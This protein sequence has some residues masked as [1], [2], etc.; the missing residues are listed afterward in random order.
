VWHC[1]KDL[2]QHLDFGLLPPRTVR[3]SASV[4]ETTSVWCSEMS[5]VYS[6]SCDLFRVPYWRAIQTSC[7]IL[8]IKSGL[9][10]GWRDGSAANSTDCSAK[11]PVFNSQQPHGGSHPSVMRS[12]TVLWY[13]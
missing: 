13:V 5:P 2:C 9:H 11:G 7:T 6:C 10:G 4:I 12:D 8:T 1:P 3:E